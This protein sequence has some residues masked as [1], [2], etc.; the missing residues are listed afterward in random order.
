MHAAVTA[1]PPAGI[2]LH[3]LVCRLCTG[4]LAAPRHSTEMK[5]AGNKFRSTIYVYSRYLIK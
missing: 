1:G 3:C 5:N 2:A 4:V